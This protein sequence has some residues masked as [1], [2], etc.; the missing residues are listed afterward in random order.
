MIDA[1]IYLGLFIF[2][3]LLK[4]ILEQILKIVDKKFNKLQ[5]ILICIL[6]H[7][8]LLKPF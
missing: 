4:F 5:H 6:Q 3:K 7:N 2:H 8:E 1:K